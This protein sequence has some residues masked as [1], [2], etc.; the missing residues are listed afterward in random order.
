MLQA[1]DGTATA[2]TGACFNS[3]TYQDYFVL[4]SPL[5]DLTLRIS[6]V[7]ACNDVNLTVSGR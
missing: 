3:V 6:K 2:E 1:T 7:Q 4:A 5:T